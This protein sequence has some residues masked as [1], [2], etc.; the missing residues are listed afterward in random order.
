[1]QKYIEVDGKSLA[2]SIFELYLTSSICV[3]FDGTPRPQMDIAKTLGSMTGEASVKGNTHTTYMYIDTRS[4]RVH[5]NGW[6]Y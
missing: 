4:V 5:M 6:M 1:M 2:R 3:V